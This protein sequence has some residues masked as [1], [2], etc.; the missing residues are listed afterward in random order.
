L[1]TVLTIQIRRGKTVIRKA[2]KVARVV[3][4]KLLL[5]ILP[6][7]ANLLLGIVA[8]LLLALSKDAENRLV[9]LFRR[10]LDA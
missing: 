1:A 10:N 8:K 5:E 6:H 2:R 3:E 7:D 4:R 9:D